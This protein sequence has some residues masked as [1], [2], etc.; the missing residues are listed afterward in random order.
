[1]QE[2][3]NRLGSNEGIKLSQRERPNEAETMATLVWHQNGQSSLIYDPWCSNLNAQVQHGHYHTSWARNLYYNKINDVFKKPALFDWKDKVVYLVGRGASCKKNISVL[4]SVER[5]NPAVFINTAYNDA[6]LQPQDFV[7]VADNRILLPGHSDYKGAINAPLIS[8]PGIDGEIVC[9]N[10][11]DL[12]GFTLWTQSP[13][14]NFMRE[15]FPHL[16]PVLDIL[17]VSVM[18]AHLAC[19]NGASHVVF[20]GMDNTT[21]DIEPTPTHQNNKHPDLIKTKDIYGK[22]CQTIRSYYEMA[23]AL[24]QFAGFARYHCKTE[25]INATGAGVLGVNYFEKE[26]LFPWIKQMTTREAIHRFE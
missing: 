10:W 23:L 20:M 16:P 19:L 22:P 6:D 18:A 17:C 13:L 24:C 1:M 9:D 4:S 14:N 11:S 3:K 2:I 21:P 26:T 12:Y 7:M 5:K 15:I 8:F 25:F